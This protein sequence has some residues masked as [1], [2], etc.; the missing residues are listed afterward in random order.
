MRTFSAT[1]LSL[2]I[3]INIRGEAL[4]ASRKWSYDVLVDDFL[5]VIL[6]ANSAKGV[7]AFVYFFTIFS[8]FAATST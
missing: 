4:G 6:Y 8:A 5:F 1:P 7:T 3:Y 2:N